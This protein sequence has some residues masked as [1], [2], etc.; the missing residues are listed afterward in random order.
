MNPTTRSDQLVHAPW[1]R[2]TSAEEP[3]M[4]DDRGEPA[5]A[6]IASRRNV[7]PRRLVEPGPSREQ[8]EHI[9]A[10]AAAA[11]D[12]GRLTPWRFIVV[13][14]D[15]RAMLAEAF[16]LALTDRDPGATPVQIE[17]AREKARRAPF[18]MLAVAKLVPA[19]ESPEIPDVERIVSLGC[20]I[21]NMLLLAHAMGYGSSLSSGR[22]MASRRIH[23]LFR[24]ASNETAV[25][26]VN[27]GTTS[28]HKPERVRSHAGK[29]VSSL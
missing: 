3:A 24:L 9:F 27:I 20:A 26:F 25:C 17:A 10:A 6:L 29:F 4:P 1:S 23:A 8:I 7:S 16:A 15:K 22:A 14:Q 13:A 11:P 21:Q 28:M 19:Q 2:A 18:L 5:R 12:H